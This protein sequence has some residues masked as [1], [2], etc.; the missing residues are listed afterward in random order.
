MKVTDVLLQ[1]RDLF[2]RKPEIPR[3]P[4]EWMIRSLEHTQVQEISCDD[5]FALLDQYAEREMQGEDASK[6]M[7]LLKQH[8]DVCQECC[9]EHDALLSVLGDGEMKKA[10]PSN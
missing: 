5:V 1:L 6:L 7:P 10:G 8:L 9:E 4:I 3:G 2:R